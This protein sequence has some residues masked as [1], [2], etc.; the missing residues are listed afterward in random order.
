MADPVLQESGSFVLNYER[1]ET[2]DSK[3]IYRTFQ[4]GIAVFGV[5]RSRRE[6]SYVE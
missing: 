6:Y 3:T 5:R 2:P 1:H 4:R